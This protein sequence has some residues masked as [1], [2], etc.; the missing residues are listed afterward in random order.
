MTIYQELS[1]LINKINDE[2]HLTDLINSLE[3]T[4]NILEN[5]ER[6]QSN[7]ANS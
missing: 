3:Q 4:L 1:E 7:P 6:N 5:N 2:K